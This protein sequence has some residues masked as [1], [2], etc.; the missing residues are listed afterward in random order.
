MALNDWKIQKSLMHPKDIIAIYYNDKKDLELI[1]SDF[2]I[3]YSFVSDIEV[4]VMRGLDVV[5]RKYFKSIPL[6]KKFA[7]SYMRTH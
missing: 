2:S 3:K 4:R 7:K 6:A 5:L 1:I